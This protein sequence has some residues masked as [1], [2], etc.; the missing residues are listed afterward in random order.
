MFA[1]GFQVATPPWRVQLLEVLLR[2]QPGV[3]VGSLDC[4]RAKQPCP[5]Q[6]HHPSLVLGIVFKELLN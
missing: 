1:S 6:V 5:T 3:L 2:Q 4:R